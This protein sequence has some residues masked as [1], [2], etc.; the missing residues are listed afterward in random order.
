MHIA[1]RAAAAQQKELMEKGFPENITVQ[2]IEPAGK[3]SGIIA[4]VF[5]DLCFDD[6]NISANELT[7]NALVFVHAVN[8][9]G[10]QINKPDYVRLNAWPGFLNRSVIELACSHP[11]TVQKAEAVLKKLNWQFIWAEDDYGFIAARIIAMIINEAYFALEENVSTKQQIDIAMRLGT[12]YP[13]GPFE[14]G[15]KIGLKNIYN[16][17]SRLA[18]KD[19]RYTIATLLEHESQQT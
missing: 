15:E 3:L 13:Y 14:W 7:D 11:V 10:P 5:F 8:C 2:W 9:V 17:L 18:E 12:N 4:D 16:L 6:T 1:I 19:A